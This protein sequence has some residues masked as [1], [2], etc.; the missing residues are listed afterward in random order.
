MII[1][2][3]V[4]DTETVISVP[5]D[6]LG[7]FIDIST[8]IVLQSIKSFIDK[9]INSNNEDVRAAAQKLS[10]AYKKVEERNAFLESDETKEMIDTLSKLDY[11]SISIDSDREMLDRYK[12]TITA[13]LSN[14]DSNESTST[15]AVEAKKDK[16]LLDTELNTMR[17]KYGN[18]PD[19]L[20]LTR[21]IERNKKLFTLGNAKEIN[22]PFKRLSYKNDMLKNMLKSIDFIEYVQDHGNSRQWRMI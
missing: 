7:Y 6:A 12:D 8:K 11:T 14:I 17:K 1:I 20:A 15:S 9:N 18:N 22:T 2:P 10:T 3:G 13:Y 19:V 5:A 4:L 16:V 21:A